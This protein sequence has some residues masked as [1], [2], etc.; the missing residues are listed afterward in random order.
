QPMLDLLWRTRF[1]WK[2]R[3]KQVTG[4]T[5]YGTLNIIQGVE[6]AHIRAYMPLAEPGERN[7]L[8]GMQAFVY[9]VQKDIYT[10]P[11]GE[12]L[13]Y[14][15][16]R[17]AKDLRVYRANAEACHRC[18]LKSQCTTSS[19][20]RTIH[21]N[22]RQ[23]YSERVRAYH[24]TTAYEKAM[25]KRKVWVEP[26]FAEAKEWHGMRRFRLRQLWRVNCE[27]LVTASGQ[28][29]KRLLQKRGWG[30]RPFPAQAMALMPPASSQAETLPGNPL[31]KKQ[32][33][34]V[35]VAS[36]ACWEIARTFSETQKGRFSSTNTI[37]VVY[38]LFFVI[39]F[40]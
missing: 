23:H 15:Y 5:P 29:L 18:P 13:A 32:R 14:Y 10:C 37:I 36:L 9:D 4:D 7:P 8:L 27:A 35:A 40:F 22:L 34:G 11:Q 21:R 28:N 26:L 39:S 6:D 30:R 1:R 31:L 3:P 17:H 38:Q 12:T 20:G 24:Q 16:T 2:L 25:A 19:H 33:A